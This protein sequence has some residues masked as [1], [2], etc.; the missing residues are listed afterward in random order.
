MNVAII[1]RSS[2]L[3]E[4]AKLILEHGHN[5]P[6]IVTSKEAPEYAITS[7]D[8]ELLATKINAKFIYTPKI[9]EK[10]ILDSIARLGKIDLAVSINYSGII[11]QEVIDHFELGI[12]NAHGGDLPRYR[13]NACQAW[14]LINKEEKIAICIHKM[15]GGELDSGPILSRK[16]LAVNS[17]TRIGQIY[18]WMESE[19]PELVI[20]AINALARNRD[21]VLEWQSTDP[22]HALRCYPRNPS[23][24]K[25][26][27]KKTNDEVL[28]LINASSE[29]FAGAFTY[30]DNRKIIIWRAKIVHDDEQYLAVPGQVAKIL[31]GG[32]AIVITG[33]RKILIQE[34][35]C[36]GKRAAPGNF[37][38]SI[39]KRF[40]NE[41][42]IDQ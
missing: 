16:Y 22:K 39:R 25:I 17:D 15:I 11:S 4:C 30:L 20:E 24:G 23:D 41:P 31:P 9:N 35:E 2:I 6:L 5:I 21:F 1:G 10:E 13:G 33:D 26:D 37:I 40:T 7:K 38:K 29:P 18:D 34:I 32:E 42:L 19:T 8:F 3:Y 28:R 36:D 27:W 14:A 12:L